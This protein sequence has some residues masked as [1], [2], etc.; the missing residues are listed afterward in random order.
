MRLRLLLRRLTISAP[1]M[2]VR[3]ALP[4]PLRWAVAAIVLGFC[5]AI[6]LWA[7]EF[8]KDI[9]GLD[10][11]TKQ[12]LVKLRAEMEAI[13][14]ELEKTQEERDKA[15]SIA[16]TAGTFVTAGK[17]S[18]DK[19]IEQVKQL[20]AENQGLRN[21]LGFFE[22]LI[23]SS[24]VEGVAIRGLQAEI[25]NGKNLRWQ[26]LVIQASKNASEFNGGL[27]L[28]FSGLLNGKPWLA[29]LPGGAQPLKIKQYGRLEGVFEVPAQVQVKGVVAK[30]IEGESI[31]ATQS[32]KL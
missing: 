20:Q 24:G 8:G 19:L 7:F 25:Q 4:W 32:I 10:Y 23:P 16:N 6:G 28:T 12:E 18:E 15:Q 2:S 22:K 31:R 1:R 13:R 21:D 26:V 30:V 17:A 9:A 5:A 29:T 14:A 11:G 27:E 3:S